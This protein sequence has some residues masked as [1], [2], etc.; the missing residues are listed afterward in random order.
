L[1]YLFIAV[2]GAAGAALRYLVSGWAYALL[3]TG[4][5]WGTL[6]VNLIGSFLIGFLWEL[7]ANAAVSPNMR[8]L[9]FTGGLGAFTTFS[10]FALESIN[11]FR[12]GE[13]GLGMAN[14]LVSDFL[15][16]VLVFVGI[17]A[18]RLVGSLVRYQ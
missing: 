8:H 13:I 5:P 10:T 15:G 11:L 7:F 2:G 16:I 6:V 3:G 14:V 4:F 9:I 18:G 12:D 1:Q 17:V